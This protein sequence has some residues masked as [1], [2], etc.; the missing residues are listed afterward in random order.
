MFVLIK[1]RFQAGKLKTSR[2]FGRF[3][4]IK[5]AVIIITEGTLPREGEAGR[6]AG[7]QL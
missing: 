2:V 5:M 7:L 1:S 4:T 6:G 3:R